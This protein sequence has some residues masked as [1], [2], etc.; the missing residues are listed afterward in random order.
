MLIAGLIWLSIWALAIGFTSS[1]IQMTV[2]RGLQGMGGRRTYNPLCGGY[3]QLIL[4]WSRQNARLGSICGFWC[5]RV[6]RRSR[7]R[8]S[9]LFVTRMAIH[10]PAIS[11]CQ[12][13]VGHTWFYGPS[14]RSHQKRFQVKNGLF[15]CF[16]FNCWTYSASLRAIWW[17]YLRLGKGIYQCAPHIIRYSSRHICSL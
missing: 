10:I 16:S 13:P 15:G 5:G 8:R 2:F 1:F 17:Q 3:N 9:C 11:H 4:Y 6:Y 14:F 7:V 12:H